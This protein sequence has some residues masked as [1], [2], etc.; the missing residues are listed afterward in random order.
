[1]TT[2]ITVDTSAA[3]IGAIGNGTSQLVVRPLSVNAPTPARA[4]WA[5][6]TWPAYR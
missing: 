2:P 6:E 3:R 4:S 5:A 1:M